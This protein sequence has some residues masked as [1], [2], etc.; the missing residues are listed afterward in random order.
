MNGLSEPRNGSDL[1]SAYTQLLS[2]TSKPEQEHTEDLSRLIDDL[3]EL[4]LAYRDQNHLGKAIAVPP[5]AAL[6]ALHRRAHETIHDTY[7]LLL[8]MERELDAVAGNPAPFVDMP[9]EEA[10]SHVGMLTG[11]K[12]REKMA[13]HIL[14]TQNHL[15]ILLSPHVID[16][17]SCAVSIGQLI[18][19]V[20]LRGVR[21]SLTL[22]AQ[23]LDFSRFCEVVEALDPRMGS[24]K[25]LSSI[26][27]QVWCIDRRTCIVP[28]PGGI[29]SSAL[30]LDDPALPAVMSDLLTQ[31]HAQGSDYSAGQPRALQLSAVHQRVVVLLARGYRDEEIA[32]TLGISVRTVR[33]YIAQLA[34]ELGART[35]F[36]AALLAANEGLVGGPQLPSRSVPKRA[37]G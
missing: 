18:G 11:N 6:S 32:M 4:G 8:T 10:V 2:G 7:Q 1:I 9:S 36:Q 28:R 24:V 22:D 34:A 15:Q 27:S 20:V 30:I 26:K 14:G 37:A 31:L 35:R 3:V 25:I 29:R 23:M 5:A 16:G 33:R 12:V 19:S 21:Y 17:E 13:T